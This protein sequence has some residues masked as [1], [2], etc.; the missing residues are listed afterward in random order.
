MKFPR[1]EREGAAVDNEIWRDIPGFEGTY[2][3]S[4]LGRVRS[5]DRLVHHPTCFGADHHCRVRGRLLR[6][7]L[8]HSGHHAVQLVNGE[9]RKERVN[10]KIHALVLLAFVGPYPEGLEIR[11]LNGIPSDN[12]LANLEYATRSRNGLDIKWHDGKASQRLTPRDVLSIKRRLGPQTGNALAWG[13][14]AA[15]AREYGVSPGTISDIWR[16]RTHRDIDPDEWNDEL[17]I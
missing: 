14:G 2:Q 1:F 16:G 3:V 6:P 9:K 17:G 8:M 11:H 13:R 10:V 5:L 15:L 12:R 4:D 7:H